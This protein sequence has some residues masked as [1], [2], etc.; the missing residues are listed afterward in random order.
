MQAGRMTAMV[1][2]ALLSHAC[3]NAAAPPRNEDPRHQLAALGIGYS[4]EA[5]VEQAG[6]GDAAAV[7]LFLDIGMSPD[8][9]N[10]KG[11]TAL[12]N[13]AAGG[14]LA[15]VQRLLDKGADATLPATD[16]P[17]PLTAAAWGGHAKVAEALLDAGADP[18]ATDAARQVPLLV[19]VRKGHADVVTTLL[20][21]GADPWT[22]DDKWSALMLASFLGE[23]DIVQRLLDRDANLKAVDDR[24]MTALM[25][26]AST[27]HVDVVKALLDKGADVNAHDA[28]GYTPL[29][30]A[31]NNGET[32]VAE[33]LTQAGANPDARNP[34]GKTAKDYA[35]L[36]GHTDIVQLL[37]SG[38][39][40]TSW[41]QSERPA[42]DRPMAEPSG[43]MTVA[44]AIED[45]QHDARDLEQ[46]EHQHLSWP[47][48]HER[49]LA[50][51]RSA[52]AFL[53][54]K[55]DRNTGFVVASY[56]YSTLWD[57]G[58]MI[59][60]AY[61]ARQLG[62]LD[63][64]G[65]ETRVRRIL[66]TLQH[67]PLYDGHTLNKTYDG[68]DGSVSTPRGW[69][70]TDYGRLLIWL[71]VVALD[72]RFTADAEAVVKRIDMSAILS[73]GYL[74]G[75][76]EEHAGRRQRYQEGTIGYEQYAAQGF[77]LWGVRADKALRWQENALP[78]SIMDRPLVADYRRWDRLTPEPF[79][80]WG[81]E[82][83]WDPATAALVRDLLLVQ[84]RRYEKTGLVTIT[85]EDAIDIPPHYFYYYCIYAN[86][87][88]FSVD[89]QNHRGGVEGPRW[90]SAKAAYAFDALM[91]SH[92]TNLAVQAI[93]PAQTPSGIAAGV[94]ERTRQSTGNFSV[95]T[96]AV[97]L[98]AA[99]YR[100][101]GVPVVAAAEMEA[102]R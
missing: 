47:E 43:P 86:G 90:I 57:V 14:Q 21:Y 95:N 15:V 85:G 51:A 71:R 65:Y 84:Q 78:V 22:Q 23:I 48:D 26:A 80:L 1:C 67:A 96:A 46:L 40:P 89:V 102:A 30:M 101:R 53:Q 58:S 13:A 36:N 61:C 49:F 28:A 64:N 12:T 18:N 98:T 4:S 72:P 7:S 50:A 54:N 19:A 81:L 5:F 25:L 39:A 97:I 94:F 56:P 44:A 62:L 92:Y 55:Y 77:A 45:Q 74:W 31:A 100:E 83:G 29:M 52:W 9:R 99:L 59:A 68:R 37:Q 69:S 63:D 60:G 88:D 87:L 24:G 38:I 70:T 16:G 41:F 8:A 33:A 42:I 27:G 17:T 32:A 11:V 3:T 73:D 10:A 66:T 34:Q 75:E 2:A 20:D 82:V 93:D 79:L 76:S 91:P 6:Q 35:A